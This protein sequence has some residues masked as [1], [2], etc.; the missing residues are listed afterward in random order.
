MFDNVSMKHL[1]L[2]DMFYSFISNVAELG[3]NAVPAYRTY[4]TVGTG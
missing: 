1:Y 3:L 2:N 4:F